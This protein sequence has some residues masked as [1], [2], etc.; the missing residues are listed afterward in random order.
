[1]EITLDKKS[2]EK[3]DGAWRSVRLVFPFFKQ[4]GMQL[5][6]GFLSL[7]AVNALQLVIPRVIKHAVDALQ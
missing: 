6:V 3:P 4:Y 2:Y 7:L 5:A 1:M